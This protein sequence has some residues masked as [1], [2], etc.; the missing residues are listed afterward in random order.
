[1]PAAMLI[2]LQGGGRLTN[3]QIVCTMHSVLTTHAY[4]NEG[5]YF[6]MREKVGPP[7]EKKEN[8]YSILILSYFTI[9]QPSVSKFYPVCYSLKMIISHVGW[10]MSL[11][12][13][14]FIHLFPMSL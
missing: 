6:S 9:G 1:M 12:D 10:N 14:A 8:T 11:L 7:K 5:L 4:Y 2:H 13:A 3:I